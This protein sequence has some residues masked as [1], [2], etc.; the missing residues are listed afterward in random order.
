[1]DDAER[2]QWQAGDPAGS[3]GQ[4]EQGGSTP[5]VPRFVQIRSAFVCCLTVSAETTFAFDQAFSCD[6]S[7]KELYMLSASDVVEKV[8]CG[9]HG[10][11]FAY[12]STGS[13]KTFTM[14]FFAS[15]QFNG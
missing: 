13:G 12:G 15:T 7:N 11:I 3:K 14:R 9:L 8:M 1:M 6:V 2:H 4:T 10:T 5:A